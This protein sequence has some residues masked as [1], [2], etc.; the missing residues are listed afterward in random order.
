MRVKSKRYL[1]SLFVMLLSISGSFT[2][3]SKLTAA[4]TFLNGDTASDTHSVSEEQAAELLVSQY[5]QIRQ[6]AE[7][8][9]DARTA[10]GPTR[11]RLKEMRIGLDLLASLGLG[12]LFKVEAN[13]GFFLT[14]RKKSGGEK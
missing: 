10:V 14:L 12:P 3:S 2:Y 4:I 1:I 13:P 6:Q 7:I 9:A 11:L 8:E 5:S